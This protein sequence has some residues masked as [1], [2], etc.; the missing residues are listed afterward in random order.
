MCRL[1]G[2]RSVIPSQVHRSLVVA[3]NA[4][5]VQSDRHPDGWGVAYYVDGA[6]HVT[7]SP[8]TALG[9]QLFHRVSGVVASETVLAH[10]RKATQGNLSVLNC[11]PFQHGR[12]VM[13][14]N[15]D[16]PDFAQHRATMLAEVAPRLRRYVLG[17]TDSEVIFYLFLTYLQ[18]HGPLGSR[19]GL[20]AVVPSLRQTVR[21]VRGLQAESLLTLLVTDGTTMAAVQGGKELHWSTYKNRCGDRDSCPS[22]SPEC[23]APTKT[24][25]VNHWIVSSEPLQ[26]E[27]VWVPLEPGEI[28]GV[29]WQMRVQ[30]AHV[31][32]VSLEVVQHGG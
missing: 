24:G 31:D 10:V 29:D 3:D 13:A 9:D 15:G 22:L 19:L 14:H 23:E 11:H 21:F 1:F 4:L 20:D 8:R 32:R 16:V 12:W 28:L 25:F 5:G 18:Q 6:P 26:G 7:R 30:R 17:E 27:N 2:F